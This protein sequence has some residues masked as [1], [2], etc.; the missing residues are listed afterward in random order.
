VNLDTNVTRIFVSKSLIRQ[1]HEIELLISD[2]EQYAYNYN[3]LLFS[4][5]VSYGLG[6]NFCI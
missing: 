5:V 1:L 3:M 6:I 4:I 2:S